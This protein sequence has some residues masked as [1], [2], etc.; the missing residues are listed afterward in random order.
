VDD[1]EL[2]PLLKQRIDSAQQGKYTVV[3]VDD[4]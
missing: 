2:L 1:A 4:I 3:D